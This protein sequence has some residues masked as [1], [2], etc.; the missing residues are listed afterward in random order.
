[1]I[2]NNDMQSKQTEDS[3][4]ETQLYKFAP[5]VGL[6]GLFFIFVALVIYVLFG[7]LSG[8]FF[9]FLGLG[10]FL[11]VLFV[12]VRFSQIIE[13]LKTRQAIYGTNVIILSGV[14]I[15]IV[16]VI[17]VISA[18]VLDKQ[19]DLTESK[20]FSLSPQ[21]K[22]ILGNLEKTVKIT[23]FFPTDET[24]VRQRTSAEELLNIYK[25]TSNKIQ[26]EFIDPDRGPIKAKEYEI[27]YPGTI[28]FEAEDRKEKVTVVSEQRFTSAL[29][30][31][32]KDDVKK[33]YFLKGHKERAIDEFGAKTGFS[34]AAEALESQNYS[35]ENLNLKT[36]TEIPKDCSVLIIPDPKLPVDEKEISAIDRYLELGGKLMAMF[37]LPEPDEK[38]N[39]DL[40]DLMQK[41]GVNVGNDLVIDRYLAANY[42]GNIN[43][44]YVQDFNYHQITKG[45]PP[46]PFF[47]AR[48][49]SPGKDKPEHLEVTVLAETTDKEGVSWGET[50]RDEEDGRWVLDDGYTEG[51]DTPPPVPLAVSVQPESETD[52]SKQDNSDEKNMTRMVV[53][54]DADF[55]SNQF[56]NRTGGGD[57]FLNAINWLTA[58]E[59]LISIR[60]KPPEER[61]IRTLSETE[62]RIVE[63]TSIFVMPICV[64]IAGIIVWI[65]R[66]D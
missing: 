15:G 27:D 38:E 9:S 31:V 52:E 29:L 57:L 66:R 2:E 54:G 33:V 43:I 58:E 36:R 59:D 34:N 49:V 65:I 11:I 45:L 55:A 12:I 44:P 21:S 22:K 46:I 7:H 24:F 13:V 14:A 42:Y 51:V 63:L 18:N 28:V 16:I 60:A 25:R 23:A 8:Y 48:S 40:I 26:V 61:Y 39:Q 5:I 64:F 4:S 47:L 50:K 1:M 62:E 19:I 10:T 56:F 32:T 3:M 37:D 6:V 17:N 41:W 20:I 35:V 30:K 53:T